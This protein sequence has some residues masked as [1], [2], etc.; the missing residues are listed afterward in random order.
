VLYDYVQPSPIALISFDWFGN[1]NHICQ[2]LLTAPL[3]FNVVSRHF[4]G[5]PLLKY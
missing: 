2:S 3:V 4:E 1:F 5:V